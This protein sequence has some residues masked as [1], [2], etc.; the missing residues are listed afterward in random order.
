MERFLQAGRQMTIH[1]SMAIPALCNLMTPSIKGSNVPHGEVSAGGQANDGTPVHSNGGD[2][3]GGDQ[4][5]NCL[6]KYTSYLLS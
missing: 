2:G 4:Y 5:E 6:E 3:E 1:I